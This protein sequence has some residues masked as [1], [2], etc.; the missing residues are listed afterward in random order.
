M[1]ILSG[2]RK[3]TTLF[4]VLVVVVIEIAIL[5]ARSIGSVFDSDNP[6]ADVAE[7]KQSQCWEHSIVTTLRR[8]GVDKSLEELAA[9]YHE[10]PNFGSACHSIVHTIGKESY[11][12]F[13]QGKKFRVTDKTAYCSYGFYHGFMEALVSTQGDM[14]RAVDFCAMVDAQVAKIKPDATLQCYHGIG[15]G[16]VNNHDPAT[17]GTAQAMINPALT[18]CAQAAVDT[19]QLSRCATGVFNG[20]AIFSL[21]GEYQ[22]TYDKND[23]LAIC[24]EQDPRFQDACYLSF[25]LVLLAATDRDIREASRF[26]EAIPEDSY[27]QHAILNVMALAS[28]EIGDQDEDVAQTIKLCRS[29]QPRL[30]YS[31]IQGYSYGFLE[32]GQPEREYER[33]IAVCSNTAFTREEQQA[34]FSYISSYFL[35]WYS[36]EKAVSLCNIIQDSENREVCQRA[37]QVR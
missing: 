30:L 29:L 7:R 13:A 18:L 6:C 25:N 19:D 1:Q 23:P 31:C 35:Q 36:R 28:H 27:A 32:Q 26:V 9:L 4:I 10:N 3:R 2:K 8:R 15:H 34:C 11:K 33:P 37:T 22:L 12:L 20:I 24:R 16:T 17:W 21:T 14:K 5:G